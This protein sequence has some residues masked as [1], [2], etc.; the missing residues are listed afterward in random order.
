MFI[1]APLKEEWSNAAPQPYPSAQQNLMA[2]PS[3]P[4]K[5][6]QEVKAGTNPTEEAGTG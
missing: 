3:A 2:A 1:R 6:G 5:L 4:P